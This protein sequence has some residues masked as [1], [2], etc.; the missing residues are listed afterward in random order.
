MG[1]APKPFGN[2]HSWSRFRG[3]YLPRVG[4]ADSTP[5]HRCFLTIFLGLSSL[6]DAHYPWKGAKLIQINESTKIK[7]YNAQLYHDC[8]PC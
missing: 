6:P 3:E 1:T 8:R 4:S 5:I 2:F 7:N